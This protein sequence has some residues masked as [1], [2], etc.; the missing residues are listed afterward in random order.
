MVTAGT[1][2]SHFYLVFL[3]VNCLSFKFNKIDTLP[4]GSLVWDQ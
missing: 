1:V 2:L 4:L 3:N